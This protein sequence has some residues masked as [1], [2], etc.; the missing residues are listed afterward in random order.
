MSATLL[1]NDMPTLLKLYKQVKTYHPECLESFIAMKSHANILKSNQ[2]KKMK[3]AIHMS[4]FECWYEIQTDKEM[5][6]QV[7]YLNYVG[8]E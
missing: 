8:N 1:P 7:P 6:S 5:S 2:E 4:E 3:G